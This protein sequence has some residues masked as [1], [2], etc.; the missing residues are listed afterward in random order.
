MHA[1]RIA[2]FRG[3]FGFQVICTTTT[4]QGDNASVESVGSSIGKLTGI[5]SCEHPNKIIHSFAGNIECSTGT[6]IPFGLQNFLLRGSVL[7]RCD[8]CVGLV[9]YTGPETKV[10]KNNSKTPSK[11]SQTDKTV[12]ILLSIAIGVQVGSHMILCAGDM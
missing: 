10:M 8:W 6:T 11:M 7:A 1:V 3:M 4:M 12:N 5:V 2:V 9:V